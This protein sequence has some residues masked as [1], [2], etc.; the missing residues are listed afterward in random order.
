ML[1]PQSEIETKIDCVRNLLISAGTD[2]SV[3]RTLKVKNEA[4][5]K[6]LENNI[7]YLPEN[8]KIEAEGTTVVDKNNAEINI[9]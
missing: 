2:N 3:T 7:T 6:A 1:A 4:S 8:W 5:Y 9:E